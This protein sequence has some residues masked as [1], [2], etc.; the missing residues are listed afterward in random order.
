MK[1]TSTKKL[2]TAGLLCTLAYIAT[3]AGR[4]PLILFLKYDPKDVVIV[5]GGLLFGPFTALAISVIVS[6]TE[7]FTVSSTG[8]WGCLM[9]VISSCAFACTASFLYG[10]RRRMSGAL[11]GLLGG[12]CCQVAVMMLWNYLVAP[13]YMGYSREAV[14]ELLLPAFLPFNVIKGGLNAGITL[15]LYKPVVTALR[16]SHLAEALPASEPAGKMRFRPGAFLV[17]LF[18]LAGCAL[19]FFSLR[20]AF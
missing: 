7:M 16:R 18:I 5:I 9:N 2:T 10:K 15:L 8:F 3:A 4:V 17:A 14:A 19:L 12:W 6:L 13:V 20:D 11:G 1:H